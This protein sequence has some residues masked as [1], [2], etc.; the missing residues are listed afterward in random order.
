MNLTVIEAVWVGAAVL[1]YETYHSKTKPSENDMYFRQVDI[2]QKAQQY[3]VNAVQHAR[4]NQWAN[5]DH[6]GSQVNYLRAGE[7]KT[8]RLTYNREFQGVKERPNINETDTIETSIGVVTVADIYSFVEN[9]YTALFTI[10]FFAIL[11]YLEQYSNMP[12]K[13]PESATG[14]EKQRLELT[15]ELGG[16]A[17]TELNK[18]A[19]LCGKKYQ[20]KNKMKSK[21]LTGGN[22]RIRRY[23]WE[24]LKFERLTD[25]PTSLSI[26]AELAKDDEYKARI[27]LAVELDEKVA[28]QADYVRHHQFLNESSLPSELSYYVKESATNH[29]FHVYDE[30][31]GTI[32]K[33]LQNGTYKKVQ[34]TYVLTYE[35]IQRIQ[36]T[37]NQIL[38]MILDGVEKLIPYYKLA[39]S[40]GIDE[41]KASDKSSLREGEQEMDYPKN[42]IL[43]GPPGTGKTYNTINYAVSIIENMSLIEVQ[44][45]PYEQVFS[46]YKEYQKNGQV[47]FITFHQSYGYEEFIE[48]IKPILDDEKSEQVRYKIEAGIFKL[49]CEQAQQLQIS[50][51]NKEL[52]SSIDKGI[53]KVS[54]GRRGDE[55]TKKDCFNN[56]RIRIGWDDLGE[57]ITDETEFPNASVKNILS[58]FYDEMN[59][60]DI[61]LSLGDQKH[62]DAIGFV[63]EEPKWLNEMP[64]YKRSRKVEWIAK[65]IWE[66]VYE[67]NQQTNLTLAT[68]YELKNINRE[69]INKL[70]L[71]YSTNQQ[72]DWEIQENKKNYV[73]IIDE[74]NR[75][76][77]SK[78]FG[79]LITL[80]EPTKRLGAREEMKLRLPYS[81][82]EFGVPQNVYLLGTMNTADRSIALMDTALRRRFNFIEMM[83]DTATLQ[84][85][86]VGK[87][88]IQRML[89]AMNQR[90]EVLFDREHTIGHAYFTALKEV[91]TLERLALLFENEILPLLQEYF[92]ED[93]GKIQLI[94]GDNAKSQSTRF[95]LDQKL[96][97]KNVFVGKVNFDLPEQTFNIQREAFFK[98]ESYIGIYEQVAHE[99]DY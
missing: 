14:E 66:Y 84:D 28:T 90:I 31:T 42:M 44:E 69:E 40:A 2:Q 62:I 12:Y 92:Y 3:T 38:E 37:N 47:G 59:I 32:I 8:R 6:P 86:H 93:Y 34:L 87:I 58:N 83:P 76:N 1:A 35:E 52:E 99:E 30:D 21:W 43:Y 81:K 70:I 25:Y 46:R 91:P 98:P 27:R 71:K 97:M 15:R 29:N 56:S 45:E 5:G 13:N 11:D 82:K 41:T 9:E 26:F 77:I 60:G 17:V 24:Q 51:S 63:T 7:N 22:D 18:V 72:A 54:L 36:M 74:I 96:N 94:L 64:Y 73:F 89:E 88:N 10:D 48:G 57:D 55:K 50:S 23:F 61:V 53:W 68:V 39:T 33:K 80:I 78:I 20:L 19:L 16:I 49:F 67:F 85:I 75:G 4:V 95:I 65:D 79:E